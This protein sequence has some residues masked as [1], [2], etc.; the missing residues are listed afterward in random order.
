MDLSY[1]PLTVVVPG[2]APNLNLPKSST[3]FVGSFL[4]SAQ[5]NINLYRLVFN[6]GERKAFSS[7]M[8]GIYLPVV[9]NI[10]HN[11]Y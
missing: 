9:H 2:L 5:Q 10:L 11:Y 6:P 8:L 7:L 3:L 1:C 4:C